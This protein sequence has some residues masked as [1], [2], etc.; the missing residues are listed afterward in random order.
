[1]AESKAQRNARLKALRRKYGLGEFKHSRDKRSTKRSV[2]MGKKSQRRRIGAQINWLKGG[3][4]SK[5]NMAISVVTGLGVA[6][7]LPRVTQNKTLGYAA[8]GI[9]GGLPGVAAFHF[10]PSVLGAVGMGG[11]GSTAPAAGGAY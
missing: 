11:A 5:R 2:H 3:V 4:L 10:A 9:A 8:A 6:L 1:M 7:L